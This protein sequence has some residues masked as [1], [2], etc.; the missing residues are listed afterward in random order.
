MFLPGIVKL[1]CTQNK[2]LFHYPFKAK[3]EYLQL[4]SQELVPFGFVADL[5]F[6]LCNS[7]MLFL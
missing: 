4:I 5:D 7:C 1:L 6:S 3:R 2:V